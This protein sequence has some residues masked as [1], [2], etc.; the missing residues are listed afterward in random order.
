MVGF[1]STPMTW[2]RNSYQPMFCVLIPDPMFPWDVFTRSL[3]SLLL[4]LREQQRPTQTRPVT[5]STLWSRQQ[6]MLTSQRGNCSAR[7][8]AHAPVPYPQSKIRL[9]EV[10]GGK[11][12]LP[13]NTLLKRL[14]EM[15]SL[16]I[17]SYS[18]VRDRLQPATAPQ[19]T[20]LVYRSKICQVVYRIRLVE[21][22][23]MYLSLQ[24]K[25]VK[26]LLLIV[27]LE[28]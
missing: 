26:C 4:R 24:I 28:D 12:S 11:I 13:S 9:G 14:W 7:S 21:A 27:S 19:N 1:I 22:I 25:V 8:V 2:Q 5:K 20:H 18:N 17:S 15:F 3:R 23:V 16:S 10:I 6:I